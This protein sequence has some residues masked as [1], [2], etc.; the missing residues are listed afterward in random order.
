M[1]AA[2]P[3]NPADVAPPGGDG[4]VG[5][6]D[7]LAVLADWG[8]AGPRPTDIDGSGVVGIDDFLAV[9]SAWSG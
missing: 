1:S 5:V 9:L 6:G 8:L 2:T 4:I 7:F 3:P